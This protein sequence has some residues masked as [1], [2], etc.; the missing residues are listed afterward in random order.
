MGYGGAEIFGQEKP[1]REGKRFFFLNNK[2]QLVIHNIFD[3][4]L[5][6]S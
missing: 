5:L 1:L 2:L 4:F 6:H 3:C